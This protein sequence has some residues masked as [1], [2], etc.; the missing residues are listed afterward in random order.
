MID[1]EF[2]NFGN[3]WSALYC[4]YDIDITSDKISDDFSALQGYTFV[5]I[6]DA[7]NTYVSR[8]AFDKPPTIS[9]IK[10]ICDYEK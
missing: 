7:V 5:D 9:Q 1:S 6:Q 3:M 2:E 10:A 4:L 8:S